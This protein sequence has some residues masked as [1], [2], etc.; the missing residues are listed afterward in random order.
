[1][2]AYGKEDE[3][4]LTVVTGKV[5][6]SLADDME[7]VIVTPGNM[8]VLTNASKSIALGTNTDLNF[9]SWKTGLL[10]FN[11]SP[12]SDLIKTLERFYGTSII[13]SNPETL[14]CRFTGDLQNINLENAIKI[15]TRATGTTYDISDGQI[16]IQGIGCQ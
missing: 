1:L 11:D 4:K 13:V 5:A 15:I 9:L 12:I 3:V 2:R 10:T 6:F 7:R 14:T 8:A 16:I